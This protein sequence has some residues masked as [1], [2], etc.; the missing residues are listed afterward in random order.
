MSV[1]SHDYGVGENLVPPYWGSESVTRL[2]ASSSD[3]FVLSD[4]WMFLR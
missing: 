4:H 3:A 1:R 2:L